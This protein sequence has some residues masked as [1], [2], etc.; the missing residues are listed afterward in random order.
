[1][2]AE[3]SRPAEDGVRP[4]H[5]GLR[6]AAAR[7]MA[8]AY[9]EGAT[10]QQR[11]FAIATEWFRCWQ[12]ACGPGEEEA[13]GPAQ[14]TM[15]EVLMAARF[16]TKGATSRLDG[17][18]PFYAVAAPWFRQWRQFAAEDGPSPGPICNAPLLNGE[19]GL[20]VVWVSA[21]DW[22]LLHEIH[23]GG[24]VIR[25]MVRELFPLTRSL[26]SDPG[27][28]KAMDPVVTVTRQRRLQVLGPQRETPKAGADV[29]LE[30]ALRRS[31]D[32]HS[33]CGRR[34]AND[35]EE[36]VTRLQAGPWAR[37]ST[38]GVQ[39]EEVL[40]ARRRV[41]QA[42]AARNGGE[43]LRAA[44]KA[45]L[46]VSGGPHLDKL[47]RLVVEL[48]AHEEAQIVLACLLQAVRDA[49]R[50][51][52]ETWLEQADSMGIGEALTPLRQHLERLA[53]AERRD[54]E[55]EVPARE[56]EAAAPAFAPQQRPPRRL[57]AAAMRAGGSP[58]DGAA[59]P[60]PEPEL[61]RCS[62]EVAATEGHVDPL[63]RSSV[64]AGRADALAGRREDLS[65]RGR[66][67][68]AAATAA[69]GAGRPAA[70]RPPLVPP[71]ISA[72][73]AAPAA[74]AGP[75]AGAPS[76]ATGPADSAV[77][78]AASPR[79][80]DI[81]SATP[82]TQ[83]QSSRGARGDEG[84]AQSEQPGDEPSERKKAEQD[85]RK[86]ER[87]ERFKWQQYEKQQQERFERQQRDRDT[88]HE[89]PRNEPEEQEQ[90]QR[91]GRKGSPS[92]VP[93]GVSAMAEA[94]AVLG[95]PAGRV[96]PLPE[97]KAAYRRAAMLS[98]PDRPQNKDRTSAATN[99]FQR[100]KDAF[101]LL[102]PLAPR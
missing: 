87:Q 27:D 30:A 95:L 69:Q 52:L 58:G 48:C 20:G 21:E 60:A 6:P 1:M 32:F 45:L 38:R 16:A 28:P 26:P 90:E 96:P 5:R 49:D 25:R 77:D 98:H 44:L 75:A 80:P 15:D 46:K 83:Q 74:A 39:S 73:I 51:S 10:W 12:P 93:T 50:F 23:G 3:A 11:T 29:A 67:A 36:E 85:A 34:L 54:K 56:S 43:E 88:G 55:G 76:A 71:P 53:Q 63:L 19:Q 2:G 79:G 47:E 101:D 100:V 8:S 31:V 99:D 35:L 86:Q 59:S 18:P 97:L 102:S 13:M 84:A 66:W 91:R 68:A 78:G 89:R 14:A 33:H 82:R 64:A 17:G 61:R 70:G 41:G 42:A 7:K 92:P 9:E 57:V 94:L 72:T 81:S 40:A 4:P 37:G 24:P 65:S 62:L 22:Q